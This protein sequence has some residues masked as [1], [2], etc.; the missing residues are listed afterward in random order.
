MNSYRRS[1]ITDED[2]EQIGLAAKE[3]YFKVD[4]IYAGL[5]YMISEYK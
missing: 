2:A 4:K 3:K 5:N 1:F